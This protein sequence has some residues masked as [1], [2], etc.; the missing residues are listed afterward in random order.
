MHEVSLVRCWAASS[1]QNNFS[2]PW[3]RFYKVSGTSGDMEH[4]SSKKIFSL[5]VF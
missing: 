4:H 1:R 5:L 3:H 2:A